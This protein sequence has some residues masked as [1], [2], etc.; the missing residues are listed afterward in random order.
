[1]RNARGNR[2]GPMTRYVVHFILKPFNSF[3][4]WKT[5]ARLLFRYFARIR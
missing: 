2:T 5:S 1:M 4:S 3:V